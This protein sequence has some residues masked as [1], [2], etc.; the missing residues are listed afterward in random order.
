ME[1]VVEPAGPITRLGNNSGR[2][3]RES[4]RGCG[5]TQRGGGEKKAAEGR[6]AS[7]RGERGGGGG[8]GLMIL[9][10]V[11]SQNGRSVSLGHEQQ[12]KTCA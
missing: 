10:G 12:T 2:R 9:A 6:K 11:V 1:T 8:M 7:S 4:G 3:K 5:P